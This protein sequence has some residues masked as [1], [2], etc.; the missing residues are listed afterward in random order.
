M[1]TFGVLWIWLWIRQTPSFLPWSCQ[2]DVEKQD[3]LPKEV[4]LCIYGVKYP[5]SWVLA[6]ALPLTDSVIKFLQA[7]IKWETSIRAIGCWLKF[8]KASLLS[9]WSYQP[10]CARLYQRFPSFL[11]LPKEILSCMA[12]TYK[13]SNMSLGSCARQTP[14]GNIKESKIQIPLTVILDKTLEFSDP[15]LKALQIWRS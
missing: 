10:D 4:Y 3:K 12:V 9:L 6:Q 13:C 11:G 8:S 2:L 15:F 5:S 1:C 7:S 14:M